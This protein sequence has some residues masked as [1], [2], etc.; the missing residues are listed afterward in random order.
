V[1]WLGRVLGET[2]VGGFASTVESGCAGAQAA[3]ERKTANVKIV[4]ASNGP[5]LT[6][7]SPPVTI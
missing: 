1:V 6:V 2:T 5:N 4:N 7:Y 3:I